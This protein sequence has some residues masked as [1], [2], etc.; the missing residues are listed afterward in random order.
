MRILHPRPGL[1][2]TLLTALLAAGLPAQ[3]V[4]LTQ[5]IADR[6][7]QMLLRSPEPGTA[8]D[9]VT[10][11]YATEGGGL[12]RLEERWEGAAAGEGEP[13]STYLLLRGLLAERQR[14]PDRARDLYQQALRQSEDPVP[15]GKR[16]ARLET[17][18]GRFDAA[19]TAY[20]AILASGSLQAIDRI[21][22]LRELALL[23][24]RAFA[25]EK[26]LAVWEQAVEEFPEDRFVIEGAG[27]AFLEA[28]EYERAEQLFAKLAAAA[29]DDP[30]RR[31]AAVLRRARA[32]ELGGK[33]AEAVALYD[34][35]L[36]ETSEGSWL[37]REI[38][39]RIEELF[40]RRD[41]L[42]G[43][44]SYYEARVAEYPRD[45]EAFAAQSLVL[46]ELARS[47]ESVDALRK[48][49]ELAPARDD[50]QVALAR[51][52]ADQG[53]LDAAIETAR[54]L[55]AR[56]EPPDAALLLL[57]ELEW[58]R[59][60]QSGDP[61]DR[62]AAVGTWAR[63]AP[64]GT[65]DPS[66][67][68]RLAELYASKGLAEEAE[69]EWR[70]LLE[71]SP[72]ATDAR[73]RLAS[74]AYEEGDEAAGNALLRGMITE[75]ATGDDFVTLSRLQLELE[76]PDEAARSL[77][78]GLERFPDHYDLL[79]QAWNRA[80]EEN[81]TA[82]L[83]TLFP[84]LWRNAPN[85]FF[86]EDTVKRMV[87][88][89][90]ENDA[91]D[92]RAGELRKRFESEAGLDPADE[93]L[94]FALA[95]EQKDAPLARA[96]LERI[97]DSGDR[98]TAFRLG[99]RY[100]ET[101]EGPEAQ[102]TA[103]QELADH[104]PRLATDSLRKIAAI[105]AANGETD[106]AL[107]TLES[108]IDRA[109]GESEFYR[110]YADTAANAG[111]LADA[112]GMLDQGL[113]FVEEPEPLR[114]LLADLLATQ[115]KTLEAY[116][117]LQEAFEQSES[118]AARMAVFRRMVQFAAM[119]GELNSLVASLEEKQRR[120]L[121]GARYGRYLAEVHLLQNDFGRAR[122]E[123][124]KSLGREPDDPIAIER[125]LQLALRE[126]NP[127][128]VLRLAKR[129][130]E[131]EPSDAN[132]ARL[133]ELQFQQGEAG[134]AAA[135]LL[136]ER[137][138]IV[139]APTA[140]MP[141]LMAAHES[142]SRTLFLELMNGL[143]AE[144]EL[145]MT[146]RLSVGK[147]LLTAGEFQ[148]A[149]EAFE[150]LV[151]SPEFVAGVRE[152]AQS[153]GAPPMPVYGY[154]SRNVLQAR[155]VGVQQVASQAQNSLQQLFQPQQHP[156][157]SAG[158]G[159]FGPAAA[160]LLSGSAPNAD[161]RAC[162]E[163]FFL[164][165]SCA[166]AAADEDALERLARRVRES[167]L[168]PV[169]QAILLLLLGGDRE[170]AEQIER[171]AAL[172]SAEV[173][174]DKFYLS[175][176]DYLSTSGEHQA[177]RRTIE[178]RVAAADPAFDFQRRI[179]DLSMRWRA[180]AA[181]VAAGEELTALI[182]HP[183]RADDASATLLLATAAAKA[184]LL[185][186]AEQ[187]N[188]EALVQLE[189]E[190]AAGGGGLRQ[191]AAAGMLFSQVAEFLAEDR[192]TGAVALMRRA[193]ALTSQSPSSMAV[194][195]GPLGFASQRNA[196]M[197]GQAQQQLQYGTPEYP[198]FAFRSLH[199]QLGTRDFRQRAR[200]ALAALPQEDD[201]AR[202]TGF[203]LA[204]LDGDE[205]EAMEK[206]LPKDETLW[207]EVYE[208]RD[209]PARALEFIEAPLAKNED[210]VDRAL[211][212]LVLL[213]RTGKLDEAK[214]EAS[215][216]SRTRLPQNQ[217]GQLQAIMQQLGMQPA[218]SGAMQRFSVQ[219]SPVT[220]PSEHLSLR[221]DQLRGE[222]KTDEA[223][224]LA[225]QV[226]QGA[227]PRSSDYPARNL[228]GQALQQLA[229]LKRLQDYV[230]GLREAHEAD[231]TDAGTT[232]RLAEA[233]ARDN[234]E[235]AGDLLLGLAEQPPSDPRLISF[236]ALLLQQYSRERGVDFFCSLAQHDPEH[237]FFGQ[238][239]L[240]EILSWASDEQSRLRLARFVAGL[241]EADREKLLRPMRLSRRGDPG[242]IYASLAEIAENGGD[243][244][245]ALALLE[246]AV[247][248]G[249]YNQQQRLDA[250]LRLADLQQ[251]SGQVEAARATLDRL[252]APME[253]PR[254]P[255]G[256]LSG[257][258]NQTPLPSL[259]FQLAA[260][261]HPSGLVPAA[262]GP[263]TQIV[264]AFERV[265]ATDK[266][267][268]ALAP[269]AASNELEALHGQLFS[270]LVRTMLDRPE[271]AAEWRKLLEDAE[272]S[273]A[274]T[275]P[276]ALAMLIVE[277]FSESEAL[278][279]LL[280]ALA[281]TVG[282]TLS[283]YQSA[284][285]VLQYL[286]GTLPHYAAF[287][288]DPKIDEHVRTML[289]LAMSDPNGVQ[290]LANS[291]N[292]VAALNAL[293][294]HEYIDEARQLLAVTETQRNVP[295]RSFNEGL[296]AAVSRVKAYSGEGV[297]YRIQVAG[298]QDSNG[299]LK[300]AWQAAPREGKAAR[301]SRLIQWDVQPAPFGAGKSPKVVRI[302]AGS[303]PANLEEIAAIRSPSDSSGV[304]S[305]GK[306]KS[307]LGLLQARWTTADGTEASGPLG[308]Y[309]LGETLGE[310]AVLL[311]AG[312]E[313]G[314]AKPFLESL[315]SS[316]GRPFRGAAVQT[317]RF[318]Y[319]ANR[320]EF[321][322]AS[323]PLG[324][325]RGRILILTGWYRGLGQR[326]TGVQFRIEGRDADGKQTSS[327]SFHLNP[328]E[329]SWTGIF[330]ALS[331][332]VPLN[333][334]FRVAS[335]ARELLLRLSLNSRFGYNQRYHYTGE[336]ADFR[337]VEIDPAD[338]LP[339][340]GLLEKARE[341][342][343]D[344]TEAARL[345]TEAFRT[346][347]HET[348][349]RSWEMM[350]EAFEKSGQMA[351]LYE[352]LTNPALYIHDP[353][354]NRNA[355]VTNEGFLWRM[356]RLAFEEGA[357]EEA[358][359][360]LRQVR[361]HVRDEDL[362]FQLDAVE[363]LQAAQRPSAEE[364]AA[365]FG[366]GESV[367]N[368]RL[369]RVWGLESSVS[370]AGQLLALA[371]AEAFRSQLLEVV[372]KSPVPPN[373]QSAARLLE[374]R[375]L[376]V[377]DPEL[378]LQKFNDSAAMQKRNNAAQIQ[379]GAMIRAIAAVAEA[380]AKPG[381]VVAALRSWAALRTSS[382]DYQ[383]ELIQRSLYAWA[384]DDQ[385]AVRQ[386][387]EDFWV[388]GELAALESRGY[389]PESDRMAH[390][391]GV[392]LER[393]DRLQLRKF[394]EVA[395]DHRAFSSGTLQETVE[396]MDRSMRFE[397]GRVDGFWPVVWWKPG[398]EPSAGEAAF[399]WSNRM[400]DADERNIEFAVSVREKAPAD[401]LEEQ[402]AIEIEF[403][404]WPN[405]LETIAT[406]QGDATAGSVET[407]LPAPNGFL[408]AVA[409]VD[410]QRIAGPLT[411]VVS[412][413]RVFPESESRLEAMLRHGEDPVEA[414]LLQPAGTAPDGSP[415]VRVG[416][417]TTRRG[418]ETHYGGP[419]YPVS[420]ERFYVA[421]CWVR[422]A[423][424]GSAQVVVNYEDEPGP[425]RKRPLHMLLTNGNSEAGVWNL[426]TRAVP[427]FPEHTF[428]IPNETVASA[429]PRF[430]SFEPGTEI[431]G[432]ELLE[433]T[434]W[435]YGEWMAELAAVRAGWDPEAEPRPE[436]LDEV[437]SLFRQEPLTAVDYHGSWL[438]DVFARA[439]RHE[440]AFEIFE[441]AFEADANPLMAAPKMWRI[442]N[443]YE[444]LLD[445]TAGLPELQW[446][447]TLAMLDEMDRAGTT[448]SL[449]HR[450][451]L[452]A[453]SKT[454]GQ[455][456]EAEQ[457]MREVILPEDSAAQERILE[458]LFRT[459]SYSND[460][461]HSASFVALGNLT[462]EPL[463]RELAAKVSDPTASDLVEPVRR[464]GELCLLSRIPGFPGS[465]DWDE[466]LTESYASLPATRLSTPLYFAHLLGGVL[467]EVEAPIELRRDVRRRNFEQVASHREARERER[468]EELLRAAAY[469]IPLAAQDETTRWEAADASRIVLEATRENLDEIGSTKLHT[470]L[471]QLDALLDAGLT[472]ERD[473]LLQAIRPLLDANLSHHSRFKRHLESDAKE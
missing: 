138:A 4:E 160:G 80:A 351:R 197:I 13:A 53:D 369:R 196:F 379:E 34:A 112:T 35:A 116:E 355:S 99:S 108:L 377:S 79:L 287:R 236:A 177:A 115:G 463:L 159:A 380:H 164:L 294:D 143:A 147:L 122:E 449:R 30:F 371:D 131:I 16:L 342:R 96:L 61:A 62:T 434:G 40:R 334:S 375:L 444:Q 204:W 169:E 244:E 403:G 221:I 98:T 457:L 270:L 389:S 392:L 259:L 156:F 186:L 291:S 174:D 311:G 274:N 306:L 37:Q 273:A 163:A 263:L 464:F 385:E 390:L 102:I 307:D 266:L 400:A 312:L 373:L 90:A 230:E 288:K 253:S 229:N 280:P 54:A 387:F 97:R 382:T 181:E 110:L 343:E 298:F 74:I 101:F 237:P 424:D 24:Q 211:R 224:Q 239:S 293:L 201:F 386:K 83:D 308:I 6:Y 458:E 134:E 345:Y 429:Q 44:L 9:R 165:A 302:F 124:M 358:G 179:G 281:S 170:L 323:F 199:S 64:A 217:G 42:P 316:E 45:V 48:A 241:E 213:Q 234:R 440:E 76:R 469:W 470:Y 292:Y 203:Y 75:E 319:A 218:A 19:V 260:N 22:F 167:E 43:L 435:E 171:Q 310:E 456:A 396:R 60:E 437:L 439:G 284:E 378:A 394:L 398:P 182:E 372:R 279:P 198:V 417:R 397:E 296:V 129:L 49:T 132:R 324:A 23:H 328:E 295:N 441:A 187:L 106:A 301:D 443:A 461:P 286:T 350:I 271:V 412:G 118:E 215:R 466:K 185:D 111:R 41:D 414:T 210:P 50:L 233:I 222:G 347:P 399:V 250:F 78:E 331:F 321:D 8:F 283:N 264:E 423:G 84:R 381:D 207:L 467:D 139:A 208:L 428:W 85:S 176:L 409:I 21:D 162:L 184:G 100:A 338:F 336:F 107:A 265:G 368:G 11:W 209:Q 33:P 67:I 77:A 166:W 255:P 137:D 471:P 245:A 145:S 348:L 188:D 220:D 172:E 460:L 65:A 256:T 130:A 346:D 195:R 125:L 413:K 384:T 15:A 317:F 144:P 374:A 150:S 269:D 47:R 304:V 246:R 113:R 119:T 242:A 430:G 393:D 275:F 168:D 206:L 349:N 2:L 261:F 104:D 248:E 57:G 425:N 366:L 39:T 402:T 249:G 297:D 370:A 146:D 158:V 278:R 337:V 227:F 105:Q 140:W 202:I 225:V 447:K 231:P 407:R 153:S 267:L 258:G 216:L 333:G 151:A 205:E 93:H 26:A 290:Y 126:R 68:S 388:E 136:T 421:R 411:P 191:T 228:R 438:V 117:A 226:L 235:R 190:W 251:A 71:V 14:E 219:P 32:M 20:E 344:P 7:E 69:A 313:D 154:P 357:P 46:G 63:I 121:G 433:V 426:F 415:A 419:R 420:P 422:R 200:E 109:P 454:P 88:E 31:I 59:F 431:A 257:R 27:E 70:R 141:A 352:L 262:G 353:L 335:T 427:T 82:A 365:V 289:S 18:E 314:A 133:I 123:L 142:A 363:M 243:R 180:N 94:L 114:L 418:A 299:K 223:E 339:L 462:R 232:L 73:R 442:R 445:Q 81:D 254:L 155:M 214:E 354:R 36:A 173:E 152:A 212:R 58:Q 318:D 149:M 391:A 55:A 364:V 285:M 29:S 10:E 450:G 446:R 327:T 277:Q 52:L 87:I 453:S 332:N 89:L 183:A 194:V 193:V 128:E 157:S 455:E 341:K 252:L 416:S 175:L 367:Q 282:R 272:P 465:P 192:T 473:A 326:G 3:E 51:L 17:Q 28:G 468:F 360:W 401:R 161:G 92:D 432:F 189:E 238:V 1:L 448:P 362:L 356:A 330:K 5:E 38:R 95:L 91:G 359:Q 72:S 305:A 395:R 410:G 120:E 405:A 12:E 361:E 148:R 240:Q 325:D 404:T 178:E 340:E 56:P 383:Q 451:R 459:G 103:L 452:L 329:T 376:A 309:V 408:R 436:Q 247:E 303:S 472:A 276:P 320:V 135:A 86:S 406:V 322:A 127:R 268:A 315:E 66:S 300:I 25:Q